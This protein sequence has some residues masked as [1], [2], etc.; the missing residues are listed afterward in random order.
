MSAVNRETESIDP[1][2][3]ELA[4]EIGLQM[5]Q[6]FFIKHDRHVPQDAIEF[7]GMLA[8]AFLL[9]RESIARGY[10]NR[11]R[12]AYPAQPP[13]ASLLAAEI[14][15]LPERVRRFV[16]DLETRADPAGDVREAHVARETAN[17]LAVRVAELEAICD[18]PPVTPTMQAVLIEA[19]LLAE[20]EKFIEGFAASGESGFVRQQRAKEWLRKYRSALTKGASSP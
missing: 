15:A 9:G 8:I 10:E 5:A 20:A 19:E 13:P 11:T 6:T 16:H 2:E 12:S 17:A 3:N 7:A 14:N 4:S 18:R 1:I